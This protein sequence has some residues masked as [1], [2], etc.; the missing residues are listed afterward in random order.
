MIVND[1]NIEAPEAAQPAVVPEPGT[2][3][4]GPYDNT[5]VTEPVPEPLAEEAPKWPELTPQRIE[6]CKILNE[7]RPI[8][9]YDQ[10]GVKIVYKGL[11]GSKYKTLTEKFRADGAASTPE[12][13]DEE[14]AA[15]G[16]LWPLLPP[17]WFGSVVAGH[18]QTLAALVRQQ[19][20]FS[21]VTL[22]G[23][24]IGEGLKTEEIDPLPSVPPVEPTEEEMETIRASAPGQQLFLATF[25]DNK[26]MLFTPLARIEWTSITRRIEKDRTLDPAE[27][28]VKYCVKWPKVNWGTEIAGRAN[29]VYDAVMSKSGFNMEPQ[30]IEL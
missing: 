13:Q 24:I 28:V 27:E 16:V 15:A 10:L 9:L 8:Y 12:I 18:A 11:L 7:R 4:T 25:P 14:I 21:V 26:T 29:M 19:S 5:G 20:G 30:V 23:Q 17:G 3:T 1:P 6:E 2:T 22:D